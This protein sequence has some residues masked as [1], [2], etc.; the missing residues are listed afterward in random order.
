MPAESERLA[1][2]L[3]P[4]DRWFLA[5]VV[6]AVAVGTPVAIVSTRS[7]QPRPAGCV[8][9]AEAGV[10]G[11]QSAL[12]CGARAQAACRAVAPRNAG[13]ATDCKAEGLPV[14]G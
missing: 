13:L 6:A 7:E 9:L 1:R 12:Y 10:V 5:A 14:G 8:R 4:R 2:R 3:R 11:N